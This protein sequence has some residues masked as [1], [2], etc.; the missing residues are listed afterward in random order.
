MIRHK[1]KRTKVGRTIKDIK[2]H[3][4]SPKMKVNLANL[5]KGAKQ[6]KAKNMDQTQINISNEIQ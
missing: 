5:G 3:N 6:Y 1:P 2:K 4:G